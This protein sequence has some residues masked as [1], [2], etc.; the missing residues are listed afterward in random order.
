[1][2]GLISHDVGKTVLNALQIFLKG[3]PGTNVPVKERQQ[4]AHTL[5]AVYGFFGEGRQTEG[6]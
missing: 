3:R 5:D 1:M 2:H 4:S 6:I